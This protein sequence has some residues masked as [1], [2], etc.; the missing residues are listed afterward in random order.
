MFF[1]CISVFVIEIVDFFYQVIIDLAMFVDVY[2][3][4][5]E[6]NKALLLV[7][8]FHFLY[9]VDALWF[10]V[11]YIIYSDHPYICK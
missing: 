6:I 5:D 4:G 7:C 11:W 1:S 10:E 2:Q 3:T 8:L 9:I